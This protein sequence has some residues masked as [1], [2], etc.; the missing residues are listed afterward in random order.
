MHILIDHVT[1]Y[2]YGLPASG[3]VQLLRLTPRSDDAQQ[4]L[5]W[6]IDID[7]DGWLKPF[8][9]AHGN[10]CHIFYAAGTTDRLTLAVSG[11]VRTSDRAGVV[12][13]VGSEMLPVYRR[14]TALTRHDPALAD[15]ARDATAGEEEPLARCHALMQA[16][17]RSMRFDPDVTHAATDAITAFG[18][19]AGVCQD[20]SQVFIACARLLGIPAR[21]VQ[22][23]YIPPEH[24]DQEAAHAW[25]EA[26]IDTLGWVG[27]D[28][29]HGVCPSEH[30]VRVAVGLDALDAAPVRGARRGGG[31]ESLE[32]V[33]RGASRT[34][35]PDRSQGQSQG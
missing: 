21:Y 25:A 30:H 19:G 29:T 31:A 12:G 17:N 35:T 26:W 16:V 33:V 9:D 27:F 2:R 13:P 14:P 3:I 7:V 8:T 5:D 32:V 23:H 34:Q 6:R 10:A 15:F 18:L 22:G 24:P 4:V 28:S 20:I 11:T 1:R